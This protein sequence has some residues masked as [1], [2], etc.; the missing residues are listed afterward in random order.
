[1][2]VFQYGTKLQNH[3]QCLLNL[4]TFALCCTHL[5]IR[6]QRCTDQIFQHQIPVVEVIEMFIQLRHL[7][8]AQRRRELR[9]RK[10]SASKYLSFLW[11]YIA[12]DNVNGL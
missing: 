2:Q 4:D 7:G 6:L 8:M 12:R 3:R 11:T 9:S 10:R 1:M 5:Q